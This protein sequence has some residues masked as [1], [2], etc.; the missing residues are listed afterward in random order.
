MFCE[1]STH[2]MLDSHSH[3]ET[4]TAIE[5][6]HDRDHDCDSTASCD[7]QKRPDQESQ[8]VQDESTHHHVL[9]SNH[10]VSYCS[11]TTTSGKQSRLLKG[12]APFR[13]HLPLL[14]PPQAS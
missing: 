13:A 7:E 12:D 11:I 5:Q 14:Q 8:G 10:L 6:E 4:A 2:A 1:V 9:V 3:D